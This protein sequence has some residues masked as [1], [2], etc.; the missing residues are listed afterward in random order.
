VESRK[1]GRVISFRQLCGNNAALVM[2]EYVD[3]F[4]MRTRELA[5]AVDHHSSMSDFDEAILP[6]PVL[7]PVAGRRMTPGS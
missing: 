7:S 6:L 4:F 5:A 3:F 2:H 1:W